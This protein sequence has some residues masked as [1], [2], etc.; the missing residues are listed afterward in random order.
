MLN[1]NKEIDLGE[2]KRLEVVLDY[3]R[4]IKNKESLH[5]V[6]K[7]L[8]YPV[9]Y[10]LIYDAFTLPHSPDC[11][12]EV[13]F[14]NF[15]FDLHFYSKNCKPI[16]KEDN[17]NYVVDLSK[18]IIFTFPW[19][20]NSIIGLCHIGYSEKFKEEW[21]DASIAILDPLKVCLVIRGN[22]SVMHGI[23]AGEGKVTADEYLDIS[24]ILHRYSYN[25]KFWLDNTTGEQKEVLNHNIALAW[26]VSKLML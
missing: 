3:A 24:P 17:V 23:L 13:F 6:I 11:S 26:E 2:S 15:P 20:R 21:A 8:L 9:M 25:G 12:F 5:K 7:A 22:H 10:N 1:Q 19:Y 18:D 4:K 16:Y 14:K